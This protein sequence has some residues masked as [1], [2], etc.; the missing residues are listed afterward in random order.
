MNTMKKAAVLFCAVMI[1][2]GLAAVPAMADA[3]DICIITKFG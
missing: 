3:L 2:I 1:M